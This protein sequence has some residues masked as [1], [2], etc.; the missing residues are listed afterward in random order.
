MGEVRAFL[1]GYQIA[2]SILQA[3]HQG[4][5]TSFCVFVSDLRL[6]MDHGLVVRNVEIGSIDVGSSGA[7][8]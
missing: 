6:S 7:E 3:E 2:F 8:I 4:Y 5:I 1:T